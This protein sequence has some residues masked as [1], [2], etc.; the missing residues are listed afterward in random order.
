MTKEKQLNFAPVCFFPSH[1]CHCF[2]DLLCVCA[3]VF[4]TLLMRKRC[5]AVGV[6]I[7]FFTAALLFFT[8]FVLTRSWRRVCVD[9]LSAFCMQSDERKRKT[10]RGAHDT[11]LMRILIQHAIKVIVS[12]ETCAWDPRTKISFNHATVSPAGDLFQ[13]HL[14]NKDAILRRGVSELLWSPRTHTSSTFSHA[15]KLLWY[16]TIVWQSTAVKFLWGFF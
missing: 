6:C 7:T 1:S 3:C 14:T 8:T 15:I 2:R 13:G 11:E 4:F 9:S 16:L 12:S 10:R 5:D